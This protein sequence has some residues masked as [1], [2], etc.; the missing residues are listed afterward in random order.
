MLS[1]LKKAVI[2]DFGCARMIDPSRSLAQ[3]TSS[4]KGTLAFLA[5]EFYAVDVSSEQTKSSDVSPKHTK[6]SDVW[7]FG[8]TTYVGVLH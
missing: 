6:S 4:P 3:L 7:A 8:M 5:P 1:S 2:C